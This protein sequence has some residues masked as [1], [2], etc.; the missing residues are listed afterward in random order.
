MSDRQ[1]ILIV[2]DK[3][4][5]LIALEQV[6]QELDV[7]IISVSSG[8]E[9]LKATL[10]HEFALAILDVQMPEMDGYELA[11]YLRN[12]QLTKHLPMIFLSAIYSDELHVFKGYEAG[13]VDFVTK[14]Y[15]PFYLNSKVKVFLQLDKQKKELLDKIEL[16]KSRNYLESILMSVND[17]IVVFSLD[18]KIKTVNNA[19]VNLWG[20]KFEEMVGSNDLKLFTND[21]YTPWLNTLNENNS[22]SDK[23]N[24]TFN[25]IEA[26]IIRK[27]GNEVPA[28]ISSSALINRN[29]AIQG[30][31]LVAV[32]ITDRKIAELKI[33]QLNDEL[34]DRVKERTHQLEISIKDMESFSYTVSH[35]LKAPLRAIS[36]FT[37]ALYEDYFE[38]LDDEG[39]G[40]IKIIVDSTR[41]MG[42]LIEDLLE[43]SRLGRQN[44]VKTQIDMN[45]LFT[46]VYEEQKSLASEQKIDFVCHS[47]LPIA[48]D[49][50]LL[51]H[52][53]SNLLANAIKFTNLRDP[54]KIEVGC[55]KEEQQVVYFVKDNGIGF[56][57]QY[58]QKLFIVFQRLQNSENYEG[59]GVGLAIVDKVIHKHDGKVWAEA[60]EDKGATFYFSL[61]E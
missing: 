2:D 23:N 30:A 22:S 14:P 49:E 21:L 54:A 47:L 44:I 19:A 1:K 26:V 10:N 45:K 9:A 34:E 50:S 60:E 46:S 43:F 32:D 20:Y 8:N 33:H 31:V 29:G 42:E 15:N 40:M 5:N 4:E 56:D 12:E 27:D 6:L 52:V 25:K 48:A 58:S 13:G 7:E 55:Y 16:E 24:F 53:I 37:Y 17:S 11:E 39:K 28:L 51:K 38:R 35:D 59:T 36:G 18:G 3:R 41:K 61:P 57:D